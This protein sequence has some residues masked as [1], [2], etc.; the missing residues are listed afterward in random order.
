MNLGWCRE[1]IWVVIIYSQT[2]KLQ[3]FRAWINCSYCKTYEQEQKESFFNI[4]L[5]FLQYNILKILAFFCCLSKLPWHEDFWSNLSIIFRS[6][7]L[8]STAKTW[9]CDSVSIPI[10]DIES[11]ISRSE[12][13]IDKPRCKV[14]NFF[15]FTSFRRKKKSFRFFSPEMLRALK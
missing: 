1:C 6:K 2:Q 14:F 8:S 3:S 5:L 10:A 9:N 15:C 13:T 4:F 12:S 11:I 7:R